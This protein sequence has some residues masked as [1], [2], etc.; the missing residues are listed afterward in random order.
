MR[1]NA[2]DVCTH[3]SLVGCSSVSGTGLAP[4]KGSSVLEVL[5]FRT[6]STH[7]SDGSE[8]YS[9]RGIAALD[10]LIR[11]I[12][13]VPSGL[14]DA[15]QR[16]RLLL[17]D[18][19][20][21]ETKDASKLKH[22]STENRLIQRFSPAQQKILKRVDKAV[23]IRLAGAGQSCRLC[24]VALIAYPA[25]RALCAGC[26]VYRLCVACE[27]ERL[28][29]VQPLPNFLRGL[30][31]ALHPQILDI[32]RPGM[33]HEPDWPEQARAITCE[34]CCQYWC[35]LCAAANLESLHACGKCHQENCSV[36]AERFMEA[37]DCGAWY[38]ANDV[39]GVNDPCSD[40]VQCQLCDVM[41]CDECM[42]EDRGQDLPLCADCVGSSYSSSDGYPSHYGDGYSDGFDSYGH[43]SD[44]SDSSY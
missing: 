21:C 40:L 3:L 4:L 34:S 42:A 6:R 17:L 13:K 23:R 31:F 9:D 28:K 7:P 10:N 18:P 41:V 35:G 2:R 30:D 33:S 11:S 26:G 24:K 1:V 29:G 19:S 32:Y 36:C 22:K 37:C 15:A 44:A 20:T 25:R 12:C 8:R 27:K 5:D 43:E 38:C 39:G 14:N 16:F